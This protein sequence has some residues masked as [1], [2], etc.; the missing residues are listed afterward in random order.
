[1][2]HRSL[3]QITAQLC[4][5]QRSFQPASCNGGRKRFLVAARFSF[6]K[7][8]MLS[9]PAS[10]RRIRDYPYRS[11]HT[12]VLEAASRSEIAVASGLTLVVAA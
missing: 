9:L 2:G 7:G 1:M 8:H 3:Q 6:Q 5:D 4:G 12:R 10:T 11:M